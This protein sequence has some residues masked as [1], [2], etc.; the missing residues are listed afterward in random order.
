MI[1]PLLY[2]LLALN[3]PLLGLQNSRDQRVQMNIQ[4][5]DRISQT[6][7]VMPQ[8]GFI[9]VLPNPL[10]PIPVVPQNS[11][12]NSRFSRSPL[13]NSEQP[14]HSAKLDLI[15]TDFSFVLK[16]SSSSSLKLNLISQP[17]FNF[18]FSCILALLALILKGC[19]VIVSIIF[20]SEVWFTVLQA[21]WTRCEGW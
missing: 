2:F 20:P 19:F 13:R 11:C 1:Y 8:L 21:L 5:S 17:K 18:R 3:L 14:Q 6:A 4:I 9:H 12:K 7:F 10:T 15:M 16:S